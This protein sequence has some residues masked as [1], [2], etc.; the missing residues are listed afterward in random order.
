[1]TEETLLWEEENHIGT[2][3]L[4]RPEKRNALSVEMLMGIRRTL[5]EWAKNDD[6]RVVVITGAG[7]KAFSS[8]YDI[9]AIPTDLSPEDQEAMNNKNPLELALEAIRN[10]PYPVIAMMNGYTFGGSLNLVMCCDMRLAVDHVKVGMTPAKLGVVYFPQGMK[11]FV[12]VL[13]MA[14]AREIF[15]TGKTYEGQEAAEMGLVDHLVPGEDLAD[16]TYAMATEIAQNAPLS[17]RGSKRIF[18]MISDS[19]VLSDEDSAEAEAL[20]QEAFQSKDLQEGQ[21]AFLQ[22]RKPVFTGH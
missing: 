3:T 15:F 22:K 21:M 13:G 19:L 5:N 6:I 11:H 17:L 12:D 8:G 14:R 7:D 10:Y 9:T 20:I 18:N 2:L 4:N 1:M 16:V